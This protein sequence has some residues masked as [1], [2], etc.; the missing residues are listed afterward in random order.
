MCVS[1]CVSNKSHPGAVSFKWLP[2]NHLVVAAAH[3]DDDDKR[4]FKS[5][6]L[7][8]VV[9]VVAFVGGGGGGYCFIRDE[10]KHSVHMYYTH[11]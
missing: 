6:G 5:P 10:M 4:A 8:R 1:V 2:T 7:S 3:G 11:L 9:V